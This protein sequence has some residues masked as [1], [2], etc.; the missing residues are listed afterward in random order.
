MQAT[1][2]PEDNA[3]AAPAVRANAA[4]PVTGEAQPVAGILMVYA[5]I[6]LGALSLIFA[7]LNAVNKQTVPYAHRKG[8]PDQSQR[9]TVTFL[10]R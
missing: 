3:S 9:P 7:L 1:M 8:P 2:R 4:I 10:R 5:S 6:G